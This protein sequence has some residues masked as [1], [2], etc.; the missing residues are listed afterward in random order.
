MIIGHGWIVST[1]YAWARP[2]KRIPHRTGCTAPRFLST[3]G[4]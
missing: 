4:G 1:V 3:G 2:P